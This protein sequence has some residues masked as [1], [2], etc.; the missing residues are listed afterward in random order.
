MSN[1]IL[2]D[3]HKGINISSIEKASEKTIHVYFTLGDNKFRTFKMTDM[4]YYFISTTL[5]SS[6][7]HSTV[8]IKNEQNVY[9][10]CDTLNEDVDYL[11]EISKQV[12]FGDLGQTIEDF[13]NRASVGDTMEY[14]LDVLSRVPA[15]GVISMEDMM[16]ILNIQPDSVKVGRND[17]CSCGSG[18]KYKKCCLNK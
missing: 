5:M 2:Q 6:A 16:K 12:I 8:Y 17:P 4:E 14:D 7:I 11:V 10:K 13:M 9:E 3:F 15:K 18:K 1:D